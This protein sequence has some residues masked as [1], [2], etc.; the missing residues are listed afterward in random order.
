[1]TIFLDIDGVLNTQ[2]DW[3]KPFTINPNCLKAFIQLVKEIEK[4]HGKVEIILT[5]TWRNSL[6]KNNNN[7]LVSGKTNI[8]E[9]TFKKNG[10]KI[11][12]TTPVSNKTRQEEIEYYIRRNNITHFITI[13]DD[14]SLF[15]NPIT[16]NLYLTDYTTGLTSKDIKKI[17]KLCK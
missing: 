14:L 3:R 8:L 12:G 5:S 11:H 15:T 6:A 1:M 7:E 9:E 10:L 17:L 2:S 13:D 4:K 16:V